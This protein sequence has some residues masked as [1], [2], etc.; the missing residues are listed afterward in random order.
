M[1]LE[2][3]YDVHKSPLLILIQGQMSQALGLPPS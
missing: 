1:E 2:V 3:N